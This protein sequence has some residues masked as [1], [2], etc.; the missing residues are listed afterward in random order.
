[1]IIIDYCKQLHASEVDNLEEMDK[2]LKKYNLLRLNQKE[3]ENVNRLINCNETESVIFKLPKAK[4]RTDGSTGEFYQTFR[5]KF[6]P[7][8]LKLVQKMLRKEYFQSHSMRSL[9]P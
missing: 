1:M 5:E 8:F 4:S 3:I 7:I 2:L 6:T 9:S